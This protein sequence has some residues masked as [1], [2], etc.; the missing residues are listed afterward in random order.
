MAKKDIVKYRNASNFNIGF[1]IFFIIII[2]VLFNIFFY[3]TK[4]HIAEYQ[5][6]QGSIAS[7]N[8]Y[9]GIIVRDETI[10][11]A[12]YNGYI[13]YYVKNATKVST[14]DMIYSI[15]TKGDIYEAI[16]QV[17]MESDR[18]SKE[19]LSAISIAPSFGV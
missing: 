12:G 13:N 18:I 4:S 15:D 8:I 17:G 14:S 5:V 10:E 1:L 9:Q 3:F 2:Y 11:Y 16:I 6:Q 7:N 19:S